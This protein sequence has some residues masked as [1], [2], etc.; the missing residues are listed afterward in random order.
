VSTFDHVGAI[1]PQRIWDGV[2]SRGVHGENVTLSLLELEAGAIVPEHSHLNEQAGILIDGSVTF[3]IGEETGEVQRG[4]T[5]LIPP[6]VPH[7]VAVGPEG[8]V[9]V[10]VFSPPR[11]DWA[12]LET[13]PPGPAR[14][15]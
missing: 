8:A 2:V 6:H 13:L 4:G 7:S 12:G 14:W 11:H 15:P 1:V 3:R 9:I 5:W 10:E